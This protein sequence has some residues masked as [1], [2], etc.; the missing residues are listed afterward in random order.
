MHYRNSALDDFVAHR[1]IVC[2]TV[3]DV[4]TAH[5]KAWIEPLVILPLA[6]VIVGKLVSCTIQ[7][8]LPVQI[9][10]DIGIKRRF[11]FFTAG[12]LREREIH[13]AVIPV[14]IKVLVAITCSVIIIVRPQRRI[15]GIAVIYSQRA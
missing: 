5:L 11:T 2:R 12:Q 15:G 3:G 7:P 9:D 10:V 4:R 6:A 14:V 1:L 13:I 8:C